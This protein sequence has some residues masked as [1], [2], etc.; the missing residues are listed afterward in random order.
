MVCSALGT[1]VGRL[2][3]GARGVGVD[4]ARGAK[5]VGSYGLLALNFTSNDASNRRAYSKI[6]LSG[7]LS[8]SSVLLALL[9][10]YKITNR[11]GRQLAEVLNYL[12]E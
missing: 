2:R 3:G 11:V 10:Y 8:R 4:R 7:L 6:V 9:L 12:R 5:G 1:V